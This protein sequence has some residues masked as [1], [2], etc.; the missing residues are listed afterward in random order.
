MT[1]TKAA[2]VHPRARRADWMIA[3]LVALTLVAAAVLFLS[4]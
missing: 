2:G 3:A 4:R 1:E